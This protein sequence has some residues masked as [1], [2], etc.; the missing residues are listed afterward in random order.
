MKKLVI[1]S[2]MLIILSMHAKTVIINDKEF[3]VSVLKEDNNEILIQCSFGSFDL[4]DVKSEGKI[5]QKI[6]WGRNPYIQEKGAPELPKAVKSII[7]DGKSSYGI[8]VVKSEFKEY[9]TNLIS[10]KG[11]IGRDMEISDIPY[12]FSDV[13]SSDK[14]YPGGMCELG[15]PYIFREFRGN[16]ISFYPFQY[17]PV[18]GSL[19]V[20]HNM[21]VKIVKDG[22]SGTNVLAVPASSISPQF[23][24]IYKNHFINYSSNNE[25][26]YPSVYE[27]GKILVISPATYVEEIQPYIDWKISK[28]IETEL[29]TVESIGTTPDQIFQYIQNEYNASMGINPLTFVQLVGD[30]DLMPTYTHQYTNGTALRIGAADAMYSLLSGNDSYPEIFVGRFSCDTEAELTIQVNKTIN[31]E[32]NITSGDWLH[33]ATG[34][35]SNLGTNQGDDSEADNVHMNNIRAD[36]LNY[37]YTEVDTI[38]SPYGTTE[39]GMNAIN[40]GRGFINYTGHGSTTSWVNGSRLTNQN[41][42]TLANDNMLPFVFAVA[43]LN[44]NFDGNDCFAEEWLKASNDQTGEPTGAVAFYGSSVAQAW[45]PPMCAQ[46]ESTDLLIAEEVSTIGGLFYSGSCQMIDEY[47]VLDIGEN[48]FKTWIIF[49]DASLQL[50]TDT[51]TAMNISHV[52]TIYT[53][54][55]SLLV[56]TDTPEALTALTYGN[57]I[58]ASG[59]TDDAG[60]INLTWN[61]NELPD[62]P[63]DLKLTVTAFN[64]ITYSSTIMLTPPD[65]PCLALNGFSTATAPEYNSTSLISLDIENFGNQTGNN[66]NFVLSSVNQYINI[67]DST[68]TLAQLSSGSSM[69]MNDVFEVEILDNVPDQTTIPFILNITSDESNWMFRSELTVNAPKFSVSSFNIVDDPND[70]NEE[71]DPGENLTLEIG[72]SNSG[73]ATSEAG[74]LNL[75]SPSAA[76]VFL[77]RTSDLTALQSGQEQVFQFNVRIADSTSSGT[78]LPVGISAESGAYV[79]HESRFIEIGSVFDGF[80]N[81]LNTFNWQ[82]GGDSDWHIVSEYVYEGANCLESGDTATGE[83]SEVWCTVSLPVNGLLSFYKKVSSTQNFSYLEFYIDGSLEDQWSGE[84]DWEYVEYA[85]SSGYHELKWVYR[86]SPYIVQDPTQNKCWLDNITLPS[87]GS[88]TTALMSIESDTIEFERDTNTEPMRRGFSIVNYGNI[89]LNGTMFID[90]DDFY[91]EQNGTI[92]RTLDFSVQP[93]TESVYTIVYDAQSNGNHT[94]TLTITS[95]DPY[96]PIQVSLSG[97]TNVGNDDNELT[98]ETGIQGIY[99]NPFNPETNVSFNLKNDAD[100]E[101]S[102]Y[103]VKGQKVKTL[104]REYFTKGEHVVTWKGKDDNNGSV[105]SGVYFIRLKTGKTQQ[106]K[107]AILLK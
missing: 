53:V 85:L 9:S 14:Y 36:L 80:E 48:L 91:V 39:M 64:K 89:V 33:K 95:N 70:N 58:I 67:T 38:Y 44:G 35:A 5:Y 74:F 41:I 82:T 86:H 47:T 32:K 28:G 88:S 71:A 69:Q 54:N 106:I 55:E 68:A 81:G 49:G 42:E 63:A 16:T 105:S 8:E 7:I 87:N 76:L 97:Y 99:P 104:K 65:G 37:N 20:Y 56:Q 43:C 72:V 62:A 29:V 50:R 51:P 11:I 24:Q 93:E 79:S 15:K 77:D 2:L 92:F 107:K 30:A 18:T 45:A 3:E 12:T 66:I 19:K 17:N 78:I 13:Y 102:V 46:D 57:V 31:Y 1:L 98:Y 59:Y 94:G 4:H 101:I 83:T 25:V 27:I 52:Q 103:N 34:V 40:A 21:T 73:H 61:E 84:T 100:V 60:S 10:S 26:L 6:D 96:S 75:F 22:Y 90:S 23:E